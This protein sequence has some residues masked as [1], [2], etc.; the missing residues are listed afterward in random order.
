MRN[1]AKLTVAVAV[2]A[3]VAL[4]LGT[5]AAR[6]VEDVFAGKVLILTKRP[7]THFRS[8]GA[9]VRFLR[10]HSTKK[11][12]ENADHEWVFETMAFFRRPLGDYEVQVA[13]YDITDGKSR[14]A[15]EFA[16]GYSQQTM[17]R[18][19]RIFA[20]KA[21][22]RRPHFDAKRRYMM[23]VKNRDRTLA[24]G[25]FQTLGVSQAAIDQQKRF[26]HEMKKMEKE[27]EEL[28]KKAKEQE[29]QEKREQEKKDKEAAEGLF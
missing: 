22:L 2:V 11:V 21:R 7:P 5:A 16:D 24:K 1:A 9:F 28:K 18:N 25:Y 12:H 23:E 10:S 13:F 15:R 29:E 27:M 26:E 3:M 4:G 20:H 8:K 19:T 17:D 6:G 14:G